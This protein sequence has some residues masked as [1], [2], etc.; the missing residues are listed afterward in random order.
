MFVSKIISPTLSARLQTREHKRS[1]DFLPTPYG[2]TLAH[3]SS[4]SH[5]KNPTNIGF[6]HRTLFPPQLIHPTPHN[7]GCDD[8]VFFCNLCRL[9]NPSQTF[10]QKL[11]RYQPRSAILVFQTRHQIPKAERMRLCSRR[12]YGGG[13]SCEGPCAA[14]FRLDGFQEG[15]D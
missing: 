3:S 1:G 10:F 15:E 8:V 13:A 11:L 5:Y 6:I 7:G 12:S 2:R 9:R 14:R 4:C